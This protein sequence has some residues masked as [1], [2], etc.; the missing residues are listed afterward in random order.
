[1]GDS[2]TVSRAQI[3]GLSWQLAWYFR[4]PFH[5]PGSKTWKCDAGNACISDFSWTQ[6][7]KIE[8]SIFSF[9]WK[10]CNCFWGCWM[11]PC[12]SYLCVYSTAYNGRHVQSRSTWCLFYVHQLLGLLLLSCLSRGLSGVSNTNRR[13]ASWTT[14]TVELLQTSVHPL[15]CLLLSS[16]F[17]GPN[18]FEL[19]FRNTRGSRTAQS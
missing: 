18:K 14:F 13:S 10:Q 15:L 12:Q 8:S 16:V 6:R 3:H 19:F 11:M 9:P 5:L 2:N 4:G 1:M 7:Y 17:L